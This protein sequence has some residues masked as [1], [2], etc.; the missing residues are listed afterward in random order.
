[1]S[2][3][4]LTGLPILPIT[5]NIEGK[6]QLSSWDHFLIPLPFCRCRIVLEKPVLVPREATDEQ[7]E[8][9]RAGLERTL[10]QISGI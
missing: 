6:I 1:M 10:R 2:L 7:R 5:Y 3:A 4:Q 9:A 8:E